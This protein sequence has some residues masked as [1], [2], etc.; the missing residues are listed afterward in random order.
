MGR[1]T[2]AAV[3]VAALVV[4]GGWFAY[5]YARTVVHDSY[6][7]WWVADLTIEHL[8][9]NDGAWP[10]GWDDLSDDYETFTATHGRP[11]SFE[12]LRSRV[13]VD[14]NAD[15]KQLATL[16]ANGEKFRVIRL[17]DGSDYHYQGREPNEMIGRFLCEKQQ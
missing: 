16:A 15:P 5:R 3:V 12:E 13:A 7:V 17:T 11:W 6:A 10:K 14:W 8:K 4:G 1:K 9:A 2:L